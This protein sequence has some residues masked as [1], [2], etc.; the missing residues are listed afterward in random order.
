MVT[1]D[2]SD[3]RAAI[4]GE[5]PEPLRGAMRER[6]SRD[7][8]IRLLAFSPSHTSLGVRS[9]AT[10]LALT[11]RRWLLASDD[12][13]GRAAVD[14]CAYDD[15]LLVELTEILLYGRLKI[16][17]VAVGEPRAVAAEFNTVADRLYG[18]AVLEILRRVEPDRADAPPW[19]PIIAPAIQSWP[20][21]FRNAAAEVLP[22]GRRLAGAIQW[23]ALQGG[24]GRELAPAAAILVTD[25]ELLHLS[26]EKAWARGPRQAKYGYIATFFPLARLA[27]FAIHG[28]GRLGILDLRLH[29]SHGGETL[30]ILFP[31][32]RES[33]VSQVVQ[34][35]LRR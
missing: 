20:I 29:A 13:D 23:P 24:F 7:D 2:R 6:L 15:T 28:N 5:M 31:A 22:E 34:C 18:E 10:L 17:F 35:A 12:E 21:L 26:E 8:S 27:G 32:R 11:D 3:R 9:P 4:L 33:E 19:M 25:H 16:D 1:D 14:E 30:Q